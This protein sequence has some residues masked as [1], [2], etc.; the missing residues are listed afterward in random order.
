[1]SFK[2]VIDQASSSLS[3]EKL[4]PSQ[5]SGVGDQAAGGAV[6]GGGAAANRSVK[7]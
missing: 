3:H 1:V 7:Q 2:E 5:G 6:Q 4:T